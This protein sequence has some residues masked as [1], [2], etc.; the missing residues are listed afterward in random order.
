MSRVVVRIVATAC[1][2]AAVIPIFAVVLVS[3]SLVLLLQ[4]LWRHSYLGPLTLSGD[5]RAEI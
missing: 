1:Y 5:S 2:V 4:L 3:E